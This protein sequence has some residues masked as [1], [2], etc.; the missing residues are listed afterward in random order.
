M[1][2]WVEWVSGLVGPNLE[3]CKWGESYKNRSVDR[4]EC[5]LAT[6]PYHDS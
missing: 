1:V 3:L 5:C 2:V 4:H 6:A